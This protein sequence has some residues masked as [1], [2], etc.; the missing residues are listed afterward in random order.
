MFCSDLVF[1]LFINNY[2]AVTTILKW[3]LDR[4]FEWYLVFALSVI[5][6]V[7]TSCLYIARE[8]NIMQ[9]SR[10]GK[11]GRAGRNEI[12]SYPPLNSIN[13]RL[14][15][16]A[17]WQRLQLQR[18]HTETW[19][20]RMSDRSHSVSKRRFI[21]FYSTSD[22]FKF[23]RKLCYDGPCQCSQ[24]NELTDFY[25]VALYIKSFFSSWFGIVTRFLDIVANFSSGSIF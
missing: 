3:S 19:S 16:S 17:P 20:V 13:N 10:Q 23:S 6:R 1:C 2:T 14:V 24:S 21:R 18:G 22:F 9:A 7:V 4:N 12:S 11:S 5:T 15:R 25:T 8:Y